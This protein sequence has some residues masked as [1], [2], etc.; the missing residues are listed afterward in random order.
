MEADLV[1]A[2]AAPT[3]SVP[4]SVL[5]DTTLRAGRLVTRMQALFTSLVG[6]VDAQGFPDGFGAS[7]TAAWLQHRLLISPG[8][9]HTTVKVA[10][11]IRSEGTVVGEALGAAQ[12][13]F[14]HAAAVTRALTELPGDVDPDIR[15]AAE[16]TLVTHAQQFD[17]V[18]V[19]RLGRRILS[20]IAPDLWEQRE[21]NRMSK[22]DALAA[23]CRDLTFS[24]DGHGLVWLRGRLDCE[25]A[26]IVHAALNP[27]STPLPLTP[28]GPDRRSASHR[29]GDALVELCRR[30]LTTGDLP[31][32][33]SE[34]PTVV[35][36]IDI[37]RLRE[38]TGIAT[39][40]NAVTL[41]AAAARRIACDAA[42]LPTVLGGAGQPLDVGRQQRLFTRAPR[43]ALILRDHGCA[44][45]GCD[46]P[47]TWCEAHHITH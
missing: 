10:R 47:P 36:T 28:E 19:A 18:V 35:I 41:T 33:G 46:R 42:I 13:S 32:C 6:E 14:G 34:R 2:L 40:D 7:S 16:A 1:A 20:L 37:D 38:S 25:A 22:A 4:T 21:A 30:A 26:A 8:E 43:R 3:W 23:R 5:P 27:L 9:A 12:I 24:D 29:R 39:T 15:R 17:P 31:D 11:S 44:F 45:P